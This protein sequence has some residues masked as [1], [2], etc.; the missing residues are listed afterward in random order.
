[1]ILL[2]RK[3]VLKNL[4]VG[5][6]DCWKKTGATIIGIKSGSEKY[7]LNPGPTAA[8]QVGDGVII[9]GSKKQI[10]QSILLFK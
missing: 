7:I 3:S 6:V 5:E 10:N 2:Y 9:M 8:I 1:M 4:V